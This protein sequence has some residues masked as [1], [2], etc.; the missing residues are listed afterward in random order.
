M[1]T[2]IPPA[3][4]SGPTALAFRIEVTPAF[5]CLST[6]L[7]MTANGVIQPRFGALDLRLA[8]ASVL[9]LNCGRCPDEAKCPE[10]RG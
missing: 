1:L 2:G 4:V 7:A 3:V 5:C 8:P 10:Q 6:A 9:C